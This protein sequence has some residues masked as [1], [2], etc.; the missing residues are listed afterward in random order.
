M[1]AVKEKIETEQRLQRR[2]E[3]L[4]PASLRTAAGQTLACKINDFCLG[5]MFLKFDNP[6]DD[7]EFISHME[8]GE[9][10]EV[11]FTPP[12]SISK[13]T[14][15]LNAR[16]AR[17]GSDGVGVAFIGTPIDAT[18]TLNKVAASMR[19]QRMVSKHYKGMD[20]AALQETCK[21][22]LTQTV[23]DAASEFYVSI[24]GKLSAAAAQLTNFAE[25]NDLMAAFDLI[26]LNEMDVQ[27]GVQK[28][29]LESLEQ[30]F[31]QR[32]KL[33]ALPEQAGLSMVQTEEFEDW[34][35]L[36]TEINKLEDRFSAEL[37]TLELRI[38]KLYGNPVDRSTNPFAPS[39]IEHAVKAE[40]E[41]QPLSLKVRQVVYG[42]MR[43]ALMHPLGEL[44][45]QLDSILP[46]ADEPRHQ[47]DASVEVWPDT[48]SAGSN[49][50]MHPD[51]AMPI[52]SQSAAG[53]QSGAAAQPRAATAGGVAGALMNLFRRTQRASQAN[54]S[55]SAASI[56]SGAG[57]AAAAQ[58]LQASGIQ[59][60][61]VSTAFS[62]MEISE[63]GNFGQQFAVSS[64]RVVS[65]LVAGGRIRPE[66]EASA[67]SSADVFG[68][69]AETIETEK[70]LP[71]SV[72]QYVKQ[73]EEPLL[74]LAVM[75]AGFLNSSQHP[76]HRVLNTVDRLAMVSS[77]DGT[78]ND[79]KL[80]QVIQRW[81]ERI[82]NEA[83]KNPGIYEEA[84]TQL[85][86]LLLPLMRIR[87]IRVARLQ[88]G[89]EG[90]Q[91]MG[92]AN[93]LISQEFERRIAGREVPDI[94]LEFF[95][96]GWRN[97]LIRVALRNGTG[98]P[99]EAEA[100]QALD[101]LFEWMDPKLAERPQLKDVQQLLTYIDSRLTLVSAGK[102]VQESIL[103][104]LA[105]G[106][107]YPDKCILKP[108]SEIKV[109]VDL[110]ETEQA[111][112]EQNAALLGQ[113]RVGDWLTFSK[114]S[115]PL[116]LI[117]IG[118]DP[119]VYVFSNYKG[120]RKLELK[121]QEFLDLL[122]SG[123]AKHTDNLDLPL[124]DR[125]F[126][127]MIEHM[128][129]N[130]VKQATNDPETGLIRRPEFMRQVK[131]VWLHV[132]GERGGCVM[133][134]IDIEDIRVVQ[135][136]ISP[137][138]YQKLIL[139]LAQHLGQKCTS[140][141]VIARTGERTF[142]F[143]RAC[144]DR[145]KAQELAESVITHIN[146]FNF[147]WE[148]EAFTLTANAGLAWAN[149]FIEP[150]IFYNKADTACLSAKHEGHNQ[151]VFF[152][153]ENATDKGHAGLAYWASRFNNI[154]NSGRLYLRCQPIV[155]L[156]GEPDQTSHY[157]VLL[158]ASDDADEPIN[159]GDF[160]AAIER[161]KRISELD[162][163]VVREVFNW[164]RSNPQQF[165][166]VGA[167]S[168]NLSGP[169]VNSK[170]FF[171][172]MEEELGRGDIPGDKL[173]F[174]ITESAAIDS[175]VNAE[176]FIKKFRRYG[177]RFSLDD[178]GV[179]FSSFT[180]LKN[181]KVDYLKI[182]GSF[183]RDMLR[184]EVDVALVSSMHE[185]SRF[186]G[187]KTIAECVENQETLE[188]LKAIGVDYVQGYHTG[189]PM[190]IDQLAS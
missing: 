185:T 97:Y 116:N 103:D 189:K 179:G 28:R 150:E 14:F 148:G 58:P 162:Q 40:F 5:G 133:G 129:R 90:W 166:K 29:V 79:K 132:E 47:T 171:N 84:R 65:E 46:V 160:V 108:A 10:L 181:L 130:L 17:R 9:A 59:G 145:E 104:R 98:S 42:T 52:D 138:G 72:K 88:A 158:G 109:S 60:G 12:P 48:Q 61:A 67:Q 35:N 152:E 119:H 170:S 70:S 89:L 167:F 1:L 143:A 18:R 44:Y 34:L 36:T 41:R 120:V 146:Q 172:F 157:E 131:R 134:V 63:A 74:K 38:E 62:G 7:A 114:A 16:V 111:L 180:Y 135:M 22:L 149:A 186:L 190:R 49:D 64:R 144:A 92:Q 136:R 105:D 50:G 164:I 122:K 100:W 159:V 69:L 4:Q 23:Q 178:F 21:T 112:D 106:L 71:G 123:D 95:N 141:G 80:L 85:E 66:Q 37:S 82:K 93:R 51:S 87:T 118:D 54:Y 142:A 39:V 68:V 30:L 86:K 177:C 169:S 140:G 128:H 11:S 155:S 91:K 99:E 124:M 139:A 15:N 81:T 127:S 56:P 107:F 110:Q 156:S 101:R 96:P 165:E 94:I 175:F 31:K 43:E 125:S 184:N 163:W 174:E 20:S 2:F 24:E 102:D 161:L 53:R 3:V 26:R 121:R 113:F 76:A 188:Q 187:I 182:D 115:T 77:D 27:S 78:I 8:Q 25:R 117:W 176:Q 55:Q 73:L 19:T 32:K 137:A 33:E 45:K 83:D 151:I 147:N 183:V 154:L 13:Q 126:S 153:E 168:I 6:Q 173:I 75:D 57:G